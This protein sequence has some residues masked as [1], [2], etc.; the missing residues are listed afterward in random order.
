VVLGGGL[1]DPDRSAA[2][3]VPAARGANGTQITSPGTLFDHQPVSCPFFDG[4]VERGIPVKVRVQY[5]RWR[6]G[7]KPSCAVGR[8]VL[9]Q[10][11]EVPVVDL[12]GILG[13]EKIDVE[14][15][16]GS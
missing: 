6:D 4:L 8:E 10:V 9:E 1:V 13:V 2:S 7:D 12:E 11:G 5:V 3:H 15:T 16:T 14:P